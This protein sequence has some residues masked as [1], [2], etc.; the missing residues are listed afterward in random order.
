MC[1]NNAYVRC[2]H[3]KEEK[4]KQ[5]ILNNIKAQYTFKQQQQKTHTR[6]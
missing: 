4:N 3:P 2:Y 5:D 1:S 6:V